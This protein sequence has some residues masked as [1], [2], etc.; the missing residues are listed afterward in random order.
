[1]QSLWKYD[2]VIHVCSDESFAWTKQLINLS[3]YIRKR[4]F[5]FHQ[6]NIKLFLTSMWYHNELKLIISLYQKLMKS[7]D[8]V[9]DKYVFIFNYKINYIR[10]NQQW[11]TVCFNYF[12]QLSY[13]HYY[14][15]LFIDRNVSS[16]YEAREV[17]R[18]RL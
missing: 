8:C 16:D 11:I 3:L 5:E 13:I 1:M 4:V 15:V 2:D 17:K 6:S 12:I 7:I 14:F 10:L 9:H 18:S